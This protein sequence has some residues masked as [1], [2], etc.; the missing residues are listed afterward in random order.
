VSWILLLVATAATSTAAGALLVRAHP[1]RRVSW[2]DRAAPA[3]SYLADRSSSVATA[4]RVA[5]V[6]LGMLALVHGADAVGAPG[7]LLASAA[8]TA[9]QL[10]VVTVHNRRLETPAGPGVGRADRRER[11]LSPRARAV[12]A[13][14]RARRGA[15]PPG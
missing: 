10:L 8:T 12:A 1:G 9:P 2:S 11:R 14:G 5:S 3:W 7:W 4:A 15:A 13:R 6:P